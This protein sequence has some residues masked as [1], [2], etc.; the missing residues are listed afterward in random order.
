MVLDVP[1]G[2]FHVP[3]VL[4]DAPYD[5]L[6]VPDTILDVP[7]VVFGVPVTNLGVPDVIFYVPDGLFCVIFDVPNGD[8]SVL[9]A[10]FTFLMTSLMTLL[11]SP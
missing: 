4:L 5:V 6:H 9:M 10:S 2:V 3:D 8:H 1:D 11:I 7:D